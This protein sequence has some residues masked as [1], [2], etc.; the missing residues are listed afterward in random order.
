MRL[1]SFI[2]CI[3]LLSFSPS[4]PEYTKSKTIVLDS[5][6]S[7][8]GLEIYPEIFWRGDVQ[9]MLRPGDQYFKFEDIKKAQVKLDKF[10][11][12]YK[13]SSISRESKKI[14]LEFSAEKNGAPTGQK[15]VVWMI[16][17]K[18]KLDRVHVIFAGDEIG[19]QY[20]L[21]N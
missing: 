6:E 7:F 5:Q 15:G 19:Y 3:V 21:K 12:V 8:K 13:F 20:I 16:L 2:F 1:L 10:T 14:I 4:T 17:K 11:G 18:G 9:F